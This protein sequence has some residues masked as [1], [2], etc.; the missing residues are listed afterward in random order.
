MNMWSAK[1]RLSPVITVLVALWA[2]AVC[3]Q[4]QPD[5]Q[6]LT[7]GYVAEA[8]RSNLAL[9]SETLEVEKATAALAE[10]RARLLPE[11]SLQGRY[12]RA[13]GGRVFTLPFGTALNPVYSTLNSMLAAQGEPA[14]FP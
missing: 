5:F 7:E 12:T 4:G 9:R 8:L 14:R 13:E 3:A 1:A 6:S 2:G 11:V 10:A